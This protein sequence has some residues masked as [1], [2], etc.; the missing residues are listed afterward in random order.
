MEIERSMSERKSKPSLVYQKR[1]IAFIDVMGFRELMNKKDLLNES[2]ANYFEMANAS[3]AS[4]KD[5]YGTAAV[6][7]DL[8]VLMVSDSII[9]SVWLDGKNDIESTSRF[10]YTIG[11]LQADLMYECIWTRGSIAYGDLYIDIEKNIL[12]GPAFIKSMELEKVSNYP[13]VI[14]DPALLG[15]LNLNQNE[16]IEKMEDAFDNLKIMEAT[17]E[18]IWGI[19]YESDEIFIDWF[20]HLLIR[21]E[22]LKVLFSDIKNRRFSRQDLFT[23]SNLLLQYLHV[24]VAR[25]SRSRESWSFDDTHFI[26]SIEG[27]IVGSKS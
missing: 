20:R 12:V 9:L 16:F 18:F 14:I 5:L 19:K 24:S 17:S 13:R 2:L 27:L 3:I 15:R 6:S 22:D 26:R 25:F 1:I 8:Q 4:C 21:R 7:D 10:L 11:K 23:K